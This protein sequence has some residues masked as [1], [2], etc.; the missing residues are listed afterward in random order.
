MNWYL[1]IWIL[2]PLIALVLDLLFGNLIPV[3]P[4]RIF[5]R[6]ILMLLKTLRGVYGKQDETKRKIGGKLVFLVSLIVFLACALIILSAFWAEPLLALVLHIFLASRLFSCRILIQTALQIKRAIKQGQ[7]SK[8]REL[9]H[10][11]NGR[12]TND[13]SEEKII[14]ET[15]ESVSEMFISSTVTPAF[16][17]FLGGLPFIAVYKAVDTMAIM[18]KRQFANNQEIGIAATRTEEVFSYLPSRLAAALT[19][20]ISLLL[21]NSSGKEA[22]RVFRRDRFRHSSANKAQT[23]AAFAGALGIEL[24]GTYRIDG[25]QVEEPVIGEPVSP[26]NFKLIGTCVLIVICTAIL[27]TAAFSVLGFIFAFFTGL[28]LN[29]G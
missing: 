21:K 19:I 16:W 28:L 12:D 26:I 22:L 17:F 27:F 11:L 24:G 13:L 7:L 3:R 25:K 9:L 6:L 15:V 5:R 2:S 18:F 20:A 29:L 23:A 14:K 10:D 4:A 1:F 8:A